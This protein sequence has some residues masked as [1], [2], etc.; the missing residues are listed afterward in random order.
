MG[1]GLGWGADTSKGSW[2]ESVGG[3]ALVPI[4][5]FSHFPVPAALII[6]LP[7]RFLGL[8]PRCSDSVGLGGA[9]NLRCHKIPSGADGPGTTGSQAKK[10][11]T[12]DRKGTEQEVAWG[13]FPEVL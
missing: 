6:L 11:C 2:V 4:Q 5:G 12:G 8:I 10:H 3:R 7:P 9:E 13:L 1:K